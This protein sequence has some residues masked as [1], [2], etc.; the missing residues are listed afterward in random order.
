MVSLIFLVVYLAFSISCSVGPYSHSELLHFEADGVQEIQIINEFGHIRFYELP[1]DESEGNISVSITRKAGLQRFLDGFE[2]DIEQDKGKLV[3]NEKIVANNHWG[4]LGACRSSFIAVGLPSS[5]F[6]EL[7]LRGFLGSGMILLHDLQN[8]KFSSILLQNMEGGIHVSDVN[9]F[10]MSV[11]ASNGAIS[12]KNINAGLLEATSTNAG[13]FSQ[14][15]LVIDTHDSAKKGYLYVSSTN[16]KI[17]LPKVMVNCTS[18]IDIEVIRD[19]MDVSLF[20]Y[21]GDFK[22]MADHGRINVHGEVDY[23]REGKH[24]CE[25]SV[26]KGNSSLLMKANDGDVAVHFR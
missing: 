11:D 26:G 23:K 3:I 4:W 18:K 1:E 22:L 12:L 20:G 15:E 25:G 10:S 21:E 9:A 19:N 2:R 17:R 8:F 7:R 6:E 13:I 14:G 5:A 16:G 24:F